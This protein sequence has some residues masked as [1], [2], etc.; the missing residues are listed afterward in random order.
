[1]SFTLYYTFTIIEAF[2]SRFIWLAFPYSVQSHHEEALLSVTHPRADYSV[3]RSTIYS[4]LTWCISHKLS[5]RYFQ[6]VSYCPGNLPFHMPLC[7]GDGNQPY[8]PILRSSTGEL[9]VRSICHRISILVA[10][11]TSPCLQPRELAFGRY[12]L[13]WDFRLL[14][15]S[16]LEV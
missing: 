3:A 7:S 6:G 11:T 15:Y 5:M 10:A 12:G 9:S 8:L 14:H 13:Q 2:G 4:G 1:M 16:T